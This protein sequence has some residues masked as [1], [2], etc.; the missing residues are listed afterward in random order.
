VS[1]APVPASTTAQSRPP[2]G[3]PRERAT[4]DDA[5]RRAEKGTPAK[6]KARERREVEKKKRTATKTAL[7]LATGFPRRIRENRGPTASRIGHPRADSRVATSSRHHTRFSPAGAALAGGNPSREHD[8]FGPSGRPRRAAVCTRRDF[9]SCVSNWTGRRGP[10]RAA[11]IS[12]SGHSVVPRGRRSA[13]R[14][15][16]SNGSR[17]SAAASV[18][19]FVSGGHRRPRAG[20]SHQ[21]PQQIEHDHVPAVGTRR[22][23]GRVGHPQWTRNAMEFRCPRAAC[24][25]PWPRWP[26]GIASNDSRPA[27]GWGSRGRNSKVQQL[28]SAIQALRSPILREMPSANCRA[29]RVH[30]IGSTHAQRGID[31]RRRHDRP[32]TSWPR[33][34]RQS[35]ATAP[36]RVRPDRRAPTPKNF[37]EM[38]AA[39]NRESKGNGPRRCPLR[40]T[41]AVLTHEHGENGDQRPPPSAARM[42]SSRVRHATA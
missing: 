2:I 10:A 41:L 30:A 15:V 1:R 11:H 35:A 12:D 22:F 8:G 23:E 28:A 27:A 17:S 7:C 29:N 21:L 18:I 42:P 20:S 39:V 4:H 31:V 6:K 32:H 5:W 3:L 14:P 9:S 19:A 38:E 26:P 40:P 16:K 37:D 36:L 13:C 34:R 24:S 33:P 25:A